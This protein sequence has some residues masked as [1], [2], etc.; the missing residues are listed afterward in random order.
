VHR[1]LPRETVKLVPPAAPDG[2]DRTPHLVTD[3]VSMTLLMQG[4]ITAYEARAAGV[5]IDD[6][7]GRNVGRLEGGS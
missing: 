5:N 6:L 1:L 3:E 4:L 7:V 2:I